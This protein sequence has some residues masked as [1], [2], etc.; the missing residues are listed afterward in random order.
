MRAISD[1]NAVA[2]D[3]NMLDASDE[4]SFKHSVD[5]AEMIMS[6]TLNY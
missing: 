4:Y 5:A 2:V 1:N 6:M 3:A